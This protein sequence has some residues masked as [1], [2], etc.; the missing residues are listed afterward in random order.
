MAYPRIP[1]VLGAG[2]NFLVVDSGTSARIDSPVPGSIGETPSTPQSLAT[3]QTR[4]IDIEKSVE[5]LN[6]QAHATSQGKCAKYVR[7]AIEAGG[8]TIPEPRPV[9]AK[10]YGPKLAELKFSKL[11]I[12]NYVAEKGDVAVFQPPSGQA[13]GHIQMHNGETW[14][15]DFIQGTGLYPG[16][17]YRKE[18]VAYEVYRP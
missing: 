6:K 18:K 2:F 7:Q 16:P 12:E 4:A 15:S 9:Y 8:V 1:G 3:P 5:F 10:D 14:V 13:A 11:D 17:A